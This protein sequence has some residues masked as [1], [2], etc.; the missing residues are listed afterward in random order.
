MCTCYKCFLKPVLGLGISVGLYFA[1]RKVVRQGIGLVLFNLSWTFR[2]LRTR[3]IPIEGTEI[4]SLWGVV[5]NAL[6]GVSLISNQYLLS[7]GVLEVREPERTELKLVL[8]EL[9]PTPRHHSVSTRPINIGTR[10]T[11]ITAT[12]TEHPS[13][14]QPQ[15]SN[16]GSS[17][18]K[19]LAPTHSVTQRVKDTCYRGMSM[20]KPVYHISVGSSATPTYRSQLH[21]CPEGSASPTPALF[22]KSLSGSSLRPFLYLCLFI[23]SLRTYQINMFDRCMVSLISFI[24]IKCLFSSYF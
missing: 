1:C 4:L 11:K 15:H 21:F 3:S 14:V 17:A 9:K 19:A 16:V 18:L 2:V 7:F 10:L 8:Q 24:S 6:A 12:I 13:R 5:F 23:V 22:K 20:Q